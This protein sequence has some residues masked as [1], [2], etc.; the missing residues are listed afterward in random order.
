MDFDQLDQTGTTFYKNISSIRA[1]SART[2]IP[3]WAHVRITTYGQNAITLQPYIRAQVYTSIAYGAKGV[4]Y[5]S[6]RPEEA[7]SG[8]GK[9]MLDE[10]GSRTKVFT[11]TQKVNSELH[12]LSP[13]LSEFTSQGAYFNSADTLG[14][15]GLAPG[16][17]IT[18]ID[19]PDIGVGFFT[20]P[21]N[22]TYV[23]IVNTNSSFGTRVTL[24]FQN[25][26]SG[27]SEIPKDSTSPQHLALSS[28]SPV[29]ELLFKAGDGRL[30]RLQE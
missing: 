13:L 10:E 30:F 18:F 19:N 21:D 9:A 28:N 2:Q 8:S 6:Y 4:W 24:H 14:R 25:R 29:A 11:F 1:V 26:Y 12:R 7:G 15:L 17:P 22:T 23:L 5:T 3:F 27:I 16:L 20:D